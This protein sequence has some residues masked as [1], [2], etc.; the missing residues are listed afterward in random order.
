MPVYNAQ[1]YIRAATESIQRQTFADFEFII[2]DDG[3]TDGSGAI[4]RSL[5]AQDTRIRLISRA[6]T[7]VAVARQQG[8]LAARGELLASMDADDISLP[9]RFARQIEYMQA[10][11]DCVLLGAGVELIDPDG[12]SLGILGKRLAH[13]QIDAI[14]MQGDGSAI[15][16]SSAVMR[17]SAIERVGGYQARFPTTE[18]LDL[19]LRLAE[20]GTIANLSD[21]L[22]QYRH[23]FSSQNR[24]RFA[25]Q[26]QDAPTVVREAMHRR[27]MRTPEGF[28]LPMAPPPT[29]T[30]Q[31]RLWARE[32]RRS[33][34]WKAAARQAAIAVGQKPIS[35]GTLKLFYH[36]LRGR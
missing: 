30:E 36:L 33:R 20:I 15:H 21:V 3:S 19:F 11:P 28:A 32:H 1:R 6:N 16:Q 18:D 24:T 35:V 2:V 13:A 10:H 12:Q 7:G 4:L 29:E 26:L 23:H 27:G 17:R 5:A 34:R 25:S 22:L 9:E 31:R 14:M 8:F